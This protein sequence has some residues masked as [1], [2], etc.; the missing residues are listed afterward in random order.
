MCYS[1]VKY[2]LRSG[3]RAL[4]NHRGAGDMGGGPIFRNDSCVFIGNYKFGAGGIIILR[5]LVLRRRGVFSDVL[6]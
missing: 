4:Y 6:F 2:P 1:L 5:C 3:A